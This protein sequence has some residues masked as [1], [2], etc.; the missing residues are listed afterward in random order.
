MNATHIFATHA[1]FQMRADKSV[2]GVTRAHAA[3]HP[4]YAEDNKTNTGCYNC[5][6][7]VG[8]VGCHGCTG[9]VDC[10]NCIN[11]V[12][13]SGCNDC[14]DCDRCVGCADCDRCIGCADCVYCVDCSG[15]SNCYSNRH[16]DGIADGT[17]AFVVPVIA[18]IHQV[19][20]AAASAP[21]A[22]NMRD[23]HSCET[24]HCRAGWVEHLAG[25]AGLELAE[26]TSTLFAAMQIYRKSS[27]TIP[28]P[29]TRFFVDNTSA[30]VDMQR[31]AAEEG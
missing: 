27:P 4:N 24:T 3:R 17:T 11:C 18:N 12:D 6:G 19:V 13:C 9:C 1:A 14:T 30:L 29:P 8:C 16:C 23:W 5:A 10:A 26:Q 22:L 2:N 25:E 28:V 20:L 31:C 15:C 7:C 21:R